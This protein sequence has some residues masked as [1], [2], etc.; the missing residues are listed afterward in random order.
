MN[1]TTVAGRY[2]ETGHWKSSDGSSG[3]LGS[4]LEITFENNIIQIAYP[5]D[6]ELQVSEFIHSH[7]KPIPIIGKFGP[8]HLLIEDGS[9][10]LEYEADIEGRVERN[11]D[12]WV[13]Q[14]NIVSRHGVIRQNDR[15]IWFEA[16]MDKL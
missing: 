3:D 6:N 10:I 16:I 7:D 9:L 2:R 13:F 1:L 4:I 14:G 11:T 15:V 5:D 12:V 8:G